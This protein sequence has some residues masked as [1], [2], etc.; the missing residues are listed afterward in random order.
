MKAPSDATTVYPSR[1][2][3]FPPASFPTFGAAFSYV[4]TISDSGPPCGICTCPA[5]SYEMHLRDTMSKGA[6]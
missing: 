1:F 4:R 5:S 2:G 6:A 3:G